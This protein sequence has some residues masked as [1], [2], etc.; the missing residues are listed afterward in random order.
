M[1]QQQHA[2]VG[3]RKEHRGMKTL[4][5]LSKRTRRI[6][7]A[8]ALLLLVAS[9]A[10][11]VGASGNL[12]LG[13]LAGTAFSSDPSLVAYWTFDEGSGTTANDAS[14]NGRTGTLK[15]GA[16]FTNAVLPA[17]LFADPAALKLIGTSHQY[18]EAGTS[19]NLANSSFTVAAWAK[20]ST[21]SGKQWIIGYGTNR[22]DKA[23]VLGFR[24]NDHVTCAFFND[25]LDTDIAFAD[26]NVWHHIA[27]T[28]DAAT[29]R[30][31]VYVDG[32]GWYADDGGS[33]QASGTFNIGRVP[34]SEGYFSGNIDDVRVYNRALSPAEI[35]FLHKGNQGTPIW[36]R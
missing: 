24:D 7:A 14:G 4:A 6:A 8:A 31:I 21:T 32:V 12:N 19:L 33:I 2:R 5:S 28:Y 35:E 9:A 15:N 34:W 22:I 30:R 26:T 23:L 20:R 10:V 13:A 16:S 11:G 18:V 36:M 25:D 3:E 17:L 29:G 1:A 27:C